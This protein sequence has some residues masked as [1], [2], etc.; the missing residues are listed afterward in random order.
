[1][2][3]VSRQ[4]S[5]PEIKKAYKKLSKKYHPDKKNGDKDK[6]VE[7]ARGS[8]DAYCQRVGLS[9]AIWPFQHTKFCQTL[10]YVPRVFFANESI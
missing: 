6:F 10:R 1:M 2:L 3:G 7:V 5:E 4:A 9:S 8:F